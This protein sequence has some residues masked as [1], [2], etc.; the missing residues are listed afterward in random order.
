MFGPV[1]DHQTMGPS[2]EYERSLLPS[3][4]TVEGDLSRVCRTVGKQRRFPVTESTTRKSRRRLCRR[5]RRISGGRP[6]GLTVRNDAVTRT[7]REYAEDVR[8]RRELA[9]PRLLQY[10]CSFCR[11]QLIPAK[12]SRQRIWFSMLL[13]RAYVCPHCFNVCIRPDTRV[14]FFLR[15]RRRKRRRSRTTPGTDRNACRA[16]RS[17]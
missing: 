10:R 13:C 4:S 7:R 17:A 8:E 9:R 1:S 14:F 6:A 3:K 5:S 2:S 16:G 11:D 15:P 12:S